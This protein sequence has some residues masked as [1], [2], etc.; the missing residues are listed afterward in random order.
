MNNNLESFTSRIMY[1]LFPGESVCIEVRDSDHALQVMKSVSDMR[2]RPRAME[3]WK[4]ATATYYAFPR[5]RRGKSNKLLLR[6]ER[7]E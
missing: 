7:K 5:T 3:T 4:F 2:D 1:V 6:I